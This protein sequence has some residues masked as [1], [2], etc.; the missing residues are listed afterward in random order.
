[1]PTSTPSST[2]QPCRMTL[3]PMT[4]LLPTFSGKPGSVCR[5]QFSCTLV[6]SP[7]SIG[8]LS[9]RSTEPNQMLASRPSLTVPI[10]AAL[11]AMKY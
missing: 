1:M 8:S 3:W 10:T 11:S 2:V 9:P 6:P 4:Q 5:T 7:T